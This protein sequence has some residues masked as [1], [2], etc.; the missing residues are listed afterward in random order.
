MFLIKTQPLR[1]SLLARGLLWYST[2]L[3][4]ILGDL[5]DRPGFRSSLHEHIGFNDLATDWPQ[6]FNGETFRCR[7]NVA[8]ATL[9]AKECAAFSPQRLCQVRML[10]CRI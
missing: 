5:S 6:R 3:K 1:G 8:L 2:K 10:Y 9:L 4:N 7:H